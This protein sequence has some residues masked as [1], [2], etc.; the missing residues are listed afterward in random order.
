MNLWGELM[1][2][3]R[4]CFILACFALYAC[5]ESKSNRSLKADKASQDSNA[6]KVC[7]FTDDNDCDNIEVNGLLLGGESSSSCSYVNQ[8]LLLNEQNAASDEARAPYCVDSASGQWYEIS[9][10]KNLG[11]STSD[12]SRLTAVPADKAFETVS[13]QSNAQYGLALASA[14][15]ALATV[16]VTVIIAR[17]A[18]A[19]STLQVPSNPSG[20]SCKNSGYVTNCT[21]K[22]KSNQNLAV[23]LPS[24]VDGLTFSSATCFDARKNY[25]ITSP[26]YSF[27]LSSNLTCYVKYAAAS[28]AVFP[29]YPAP[30]QN[31]PIKP[32]PTPTP[33]PQPSQPKPASMMTL[34]IVGGKY[35]GQPVR[36]TPSGIACNTGTGTNGCSAQFKAGE[37]VALDFPQKIFPVSGGSALNFNYY[38]CSGDKG[39]S[40]KGPQGQLRAT[41]FMNENITC[42]AY[43]GANGSG[44]EGN[45]N[46]S[47][48]TRRLKIV[49]GAFSGQPVLSDPS[50][51]NC[52]GGNTASCAADF[53]YGAKVQTT[54][55]KNIMFNGKTYAFDYFYCEGDQTTTARGSPNQLVQTLFMYENFTCT[56]YYK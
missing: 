19:L 48:N 42:T 11:D 9:Q 56:A 16:D 32:Q 14:S 7:G 33:T 47:G 5:N 55:P 12:L 31:S 37:Q 34:S 41:I 44:S 51:I 52:N 4:Y 49:G 10:Y 38:Y 17:T 23:A 21:G 6:A 15:A 13:R 28:K 46:A 1:K 45:G 22:F 26:Q 29:A 27:P 20:L 2:T 54:Y 36:S 3:A 8:S 30:G 43:Y 53:A 24:T 18:T 40:L 50:G 25:S 35:S 39:T